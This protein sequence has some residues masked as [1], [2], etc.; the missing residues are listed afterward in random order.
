ME[1]ASIDLD[2]SI[3]FQLAYIL[4]LKCYLKNQRRNLRILE[5]KEDSFCLKWDCQVQDV[6]QFLGQLNLS[7][8]HVCTLCQMG[9]VF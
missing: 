1:I 2:P 9:K 7:E 3:R 5:S 6:F 4:G 8:H